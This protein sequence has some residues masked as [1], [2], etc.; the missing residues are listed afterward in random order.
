[1]RCVQLLADYYEKSLTVSSDGAEADVTEPPAE[2]RHRCKC[3]KLFR[4][5]VFA[6][7]HLHNKHEDEIKA[8]LDRNKKLLERLV[9]V[10]LFRRTMF[11]KCVCCW[12]CVCLCVCACM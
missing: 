1:M 2:R 9:D 7:K 12:S 6:V 4:N 5:R 8:E 11:N 3:K 10:C